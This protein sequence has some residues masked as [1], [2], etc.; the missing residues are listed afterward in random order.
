MDGDPP[1]LRLFEERD[2]KYVAINTTPTYS[3]NAFR[4]KKIV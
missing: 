3:L 4:K 2:Y 1:V